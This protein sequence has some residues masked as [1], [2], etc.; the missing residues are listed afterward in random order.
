M[1]ESKVEVVI[2]TK[3]V[4]F[5]DNY[6]YSK[7][8]FSHQFDIFSR[9][10]SHHTPGNFAFPRDGFSSF[11]SLY[12]LGTALT[13]PGEIYL[14]TWAAPLFLSVHFFSKELSNHT[15]GKFAFPPDN[16]FFFPKHHDIKND[17]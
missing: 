11:F 12:F 3:P 8:N 9:G 7:E 1:Q 2:V 17:R 15:P 13:H 16:S 4:R 6:S 10:S 14:P 5:L